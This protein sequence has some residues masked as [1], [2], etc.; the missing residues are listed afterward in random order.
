MSKTRK[1]HKYLKN[2]KNKKKQKKHNTKKMSHKYLKNRDNKRSKRKVLNKTVK[3][4]KMKGGWWPWGDSEKQSPYNLSDA[5]KLAKK[6]EEQMKKDNEKLF[7]ELFGDCKIPNI[8]GLRE[9]YTLGNVPPPF[10][11]GR[12]SFGTVCKIG[13]KGGKIYAIKTQNLAEFSIFD[14]IFKIIEFTK[15]INIMKNLKHPN[16]IKFIDAY[17]SNN[18]GYIIMEYCEKN[19]HKYI[20]EKSIT[21]YPDNKDLNIEKI[22]KELLFGLDYMHRIKSVMHLDLKPENLAITIVHTTGICTLKILD[23]GLAQTLLYKDKDK[24][25]KNRDKNWCSY[26]LI[27][28]CI[29]NDIITS[30]W[31]PP[32]VLEIIYGNFY[33]YDTKADCWS[34][35]LIIAS[36]LKMYDNIFDPNPTNFKF[37]YHQYNEHLNKIYHTLPKYSPI[38]SNQKLTQLVYLKLNL[39]LIR[40]ESTNPEI[41]KF[42]SILEGML[43]LNPELRLSCVNAIDNLDIENINN[44]KPEAIYDVQRGNVNHINLNRAK[45]NLIEIIK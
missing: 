42:D 28:G 41:I 36:I 34:C 40:G 20:T 33:D 4:M 30:W 12:G 5:D 25:I 23:F 10:M 19:L 18:I 13:D 16:I 14:N 39:N 3:K 26:E 31:R 15:E 6:L 9:K 22:I 27:N 32:E 44:E 24:N 1:D 29:M 2:I 21:I 37:S 43:Q 38:Y 7:K 8:P 11:L 45:S 17:Y 35:A